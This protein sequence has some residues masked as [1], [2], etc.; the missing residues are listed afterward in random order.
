[1]ENMKYAESLSKLIQ[2]K[3]VTN[4]G[5]ANFAQLRKVMENLFPNVHRVCERTQVFNNALLFKWTGKSNKKPIVLMG[6]QDVVPADD[7]DWK[8]PPFDGVIA[9]GRVW[10]RGAMDC[11]N[12]LFVSLQAI[13]ELISEG[14]TPESDVYVASSDCEETFGIGAPKIKDYLKNQ[15]VKPFIVLDEGGAILPEAF[16]GMIRPYAMVGVLEKGYG[17]VKFIARSDGGHSSSPPKN[18]PVARLSKFITAVEDGNLFKKKMSPEAEEMLLAMADGLTGPLKFVLKHIKVFKPLVTKLLPKISPF[19]NA[20]FSTTMVF[21]MTSASPAPNVIPQEAYAIA[22]MRFAPHQGTKACFETLEKLAK[23]YNLE[24]KIIEGQD[25]H[26][27]ISTKSA[28]YN[29][30]TANIKRC[31]PDIGIAPYVIMG[32]TDCRHFQDICDCAMRFTPMLYKPDQMAAMHASNE[33]VDIDTLGG[34]VRFMK[35]LILNNK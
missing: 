12:T 27:P 28:G 10:G 32:G 5:D 29:Y 19:G 30:L 14:F 20:L 9:D 21:T 24:M 17:D 2:V 11:K 7:G 18:T 13:E 6:H 8:Y 22:N 31:F 25:A 23:K 33:S 26:P 16:P 1:M 4:I 35:E 15:G 34:G 3:T